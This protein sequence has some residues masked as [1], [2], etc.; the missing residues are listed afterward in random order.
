M[1][2]TPDCSHWRQVIR[3]RIVE[4]L[5]REEATRVE[6]HLAVCA[7]CRRYDQELR[8]TTAGLR[9]L[10]DLPAEPSPG[11]R[12]RWTQAVADAARPRGCRETTPALLDWCRALLLR[13]FRPA[14]GVA[15][16]WALTLLFRLS[17]PDVPSASITT[18]ARSPVEIAR[19]LEAG[20]RLVAS[21]PRRSDLLPP[22]P[23]PA[24][25]PQPRS[26]RLPAAPAAQSDP[27]PEA[28]AG[29]ES[30]LPKLLAHREFAAALPLWTT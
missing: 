23:R 10:A 30:P 22:A 13:N 18:T 28:H 20:E 12:A 17:A 3:T 7:E 1:K 14:L 26:Q 25:P 29:L 5:A 11:F 15:S 9:W 4:G 16:L 21:H 2:T 6:T 24:E 8:A 19:A 27:L